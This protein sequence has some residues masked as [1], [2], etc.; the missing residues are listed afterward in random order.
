MF[1]P[2]IVFCDT[3]V[4]TDIDTN[5]EQSEFK[6]QL[7]PK[8]LE[9]DSISF[10]IKQFDK[11][12][13]EEYKSNKEFEYFKKNKPNFD[14]IQ[15]L[16]RVIFDFIIKQINYLMSNTVNSWIVVITIVFLPT[17]VIL[18]LFFRSKR[19]VGIDSNIKSKPSELSLELK[20]AVS[21]DYDDRIKSAELQNKY[22]EAVRLRYLKLLLILFE[23]KIL[24]FSLSKT[25]SDYLK[26]LK[27]TKFYDSFSQ[28]N[29]IFNYVTYGEFSVGD[30]T[31]SRISDLYNE[32]ENM[33][34]QYENT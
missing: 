23:A 2:T 18:F 5:F 22:S 9:T 33:V 14:I 32:F 7:L 19:N 16:E 8:L 11:K 25:N 12:N 29:D 6:P 26:D 15:F 34:V 28:I 30:A 31:Y 21:T 27:T 20:G 3:I 17:L 1:I 13:I 10:S 4:E 24:S